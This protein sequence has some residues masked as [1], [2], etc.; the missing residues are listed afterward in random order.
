MRLD[1]GTAS[2]AAKAAISI[3]KA[4]PDVDIVAEVLNAIVAAAIVVAFGE[5]SAYG[6]EKVYLGVMSTKDVDAIR[7]FM[8]QKLDNEF[9]GKV[10]EVIEDFAVSDQGKNPL[11]DL[12]GNLVKTLGPNTGKASC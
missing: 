12:T 10:T 9:V 5:G 4:I 1:V 7:S 6:F 8:E 3:L 11:K 2:I